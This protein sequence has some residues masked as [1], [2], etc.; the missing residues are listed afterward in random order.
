MNRLFIRLSCWLRGRRRRGIGDA[1]G[2]GCA[3]GAFSGLGRGWIGMR[4]IGALDLD[5]A[6]C[7]DGLGA[8]AGAVER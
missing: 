1:K 8:A 2:F 6:F 5:E 4:R 7:A 3:K